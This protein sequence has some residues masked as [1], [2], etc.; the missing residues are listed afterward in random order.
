V[1]TTTA[2]LPGYAYNE[3]QNVSTSTNLLNV[4]DAFD[5]LW[6]VGGGIGHYVTAHHEKRIHGHS[7]EWA[8]TISKFDKYN[9]PSTGTILDSNPTKLVGDVQGI[10]AKVSALGVTL[11]SLLP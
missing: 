2:P 10:E 9:G 6:G 8:A 1:T 7:W 4:S 11:P 5:Q 3:Y